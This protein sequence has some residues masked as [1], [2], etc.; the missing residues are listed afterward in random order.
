MSE[1]LL[2]EKLVYGTYGQVMFTDATRKKLHEFAK[3]HDIPNPL[4][5]DEF[6]TT[7]IYSREP[8]KFYKPHNFRS[9]PITV[10]RKTF[11]WDMFGDTKNTLVLKFESYFLNWRH[12]AARALGATYDFPEYIPHVSLSYGAEGFDPKNLPLPTFDLYINQETVKHMTGN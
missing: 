5:P 1:V 2:A 9:C 12:Y 10:D 4:E 7:V 3:K 11:A 8:V 6:H